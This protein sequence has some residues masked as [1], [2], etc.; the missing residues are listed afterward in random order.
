MD[1]AIDYAIDDVIDDVIKSGDPCAST[2]TF[3]LLTILAFNLKFRQLAV[4]QSVCFYN[5]L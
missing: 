2:P 5:V 4:L 3:I 1:Y